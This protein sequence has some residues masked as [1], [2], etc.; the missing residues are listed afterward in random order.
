M[1]RPGAPSRQLLC[2]GDPT[3]LATWSSTPFFLLQAGQRSGLLTGGLALQPEH[4]RGQRRLWNLA[5][6][7]RHGRPGGFQ[8]SHE[9]T[10]AL[11][12]QAQLPV[13]HPL[14][15]LSHFPLL[16]PHP[17]PRLWR[18]DFY[19]DATTHQV[20]NDY[21][22]GCRLAPAYR[23]EVLERE[24]RAYAAA[25]AVICMAQW[26][27]DSVIG[28][29]GIHPA[30][31]HVVPGG[32]NLDETELAALPV[33]PPPPPPTVDQPLRL[34]FLGKDWVRKGGPFLL[35]L[36][37]ELQRRGI[38][39]VIR[40]IGPVPASLPAHPAL[41]P[42]GF[43]NKQSDTARFVHELRSWHFGALFSTAEAFGISNRE[44]L[45]LG[46]PVLAH[47]VGGIAS[48]LPD[49]GCGLLFA[50][51]PSPVDVANWIAERLTPYESYLAWRSALPPRWRE[52]TWDAAVERLAAILG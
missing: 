45:R 7:L 10:R 18:V 48:T 25:G 38:P 3:E 30:K 41:Q 36:A 13:D 19:I 23:Q 22:F 4:L 20:F 46:V 2:C 5:Q 43:I 6:L 44:C 15:L 27:A 9:F 47:A 35:Q 51:H 14:G 28:D 16:P 24:R 37:V 17:W 26:A 42:L 21:G 31:V 8:Y 29:Y 50:A 33:L 39:A 52:F 34:G 11:L 49:A 1:P 40:V 12:A 32:A